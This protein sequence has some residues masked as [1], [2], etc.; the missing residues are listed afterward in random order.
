T[1]EGGGEIRLPLPLFSSVFLLVRTSYLV[2]RTFLDDHRTAP[3]TPHT[4]AAARQSRGTAPA[5]RRR[6]A[7][8]HLRAAS[9]SARTTFNHIGPGLASEEGV[10]CP[11]TGCR[12]PVA[13]H[14]ATVID[15]DLDGT[16]ES[17]KNH[18]PRKQADVIRCAA[19]SRPFGYGPP[20]LNGL[21]LAT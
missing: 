7:R 5:A 15:I 18:R 8:M 11:Q 14:E 2:L 6:P 20:R 21:P 1:R 9:P 19:V 3:R 16:E 12:C 17:R 4:T 13:L 10:V